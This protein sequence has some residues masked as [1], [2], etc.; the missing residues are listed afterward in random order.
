VI[1]VDPVEFKRDK[2][3]ELGATHV[4]PSIDEAWGI[5]SELTRGQL[6]EAAILTTGVA[7]GDDLQPAL[8]LVGKKGR[9]VVT[10]LGKAEQE[11]ASLSLLE[12]TLYEKQIRGALFGSS[13][14]QH[15]VPRLL[16]MHNLGMLKLRELI[17]REYTL[18]QV[19]EGYED[20]RAGRN[21]R[22]LIRF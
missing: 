20:M 9:V 17:T 19:N 16:E 2:A 1:A 6:A 3:L 22:G 4:A 21:I 8:Q 14:G 18:E 7:E 15:D 5:V 12:L 11:V 10:A 13:N